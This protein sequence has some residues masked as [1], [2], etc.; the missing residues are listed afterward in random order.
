MISARSRAHDR[1]RRFTRFLAAF[2][3]GW[4]LSPLAPAD[5]KTRYQDIGDLI[6]ASCALNDSLD[7]SNTILNSA[8]L[9]QDTPIEIQGN[10]HGWRRVYRLDNDVRIE[11]E[12][13]GTPN[14]L[15][16]LGIQYDDPNGKPKLFVAL[17]PDCDIRT[18]REIEYDQHGRAI[19]IEH[20]DQQ[21]HATGIS[22]SLNPT[23]PMGDQT[24]GV[25][26]A[27]V[28][29]G[30]NYQLRA[31]GE[32]L[33]RDQNGK[34]IGYDFWDMDPL[35]FDANP[36][37]SP[38][39][40][41]R[42]GT[43]TASLIVREAPQA[44][45]VPY[46]YPR[47]DMTRMRDVIEHAANANVRI[48]A[49]PL[50]SNRPTEWQTFAEAA[51]D[52]PEMLFIVSAGNNNRNIDEFPVYPAAMDLDNLLVVTSADDFAKP[53]KGSNW[54]PLSVDLLIPA[55]RQLVTDFS[56]QQLAASG[57]SYAVSRAA[58]MAARLLT[59]YPEWDAQQLKAEII[60]NAV[61]KNMQQY[62]SIGLLADPLADTA[63]VRRRDQFQ[64]ELN[65]V[66][67]TS[68]VPDLHLRVDI[69]LL[70]QS[71][72]DESS[73]QSMVTETATILA[74]CNIMLNEARV[75]VAEVSP[76]LLDLAM[77]T[78]KTLVDTIALPH[79]T[80]YLVRDTKMEIPFG[81]EAFGRA[82]T[83]TRTWLRDS[84]WLTASISDPGVALAHE[85]FHVI[86]NSGEHVRES[87][88]LMGEQTS[89][90]NTA[91][92]RH[93]C[94]LA[95]QQGLAAGLLTSTGAS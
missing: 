22:D 13:I 94:D 39:F 69:A 5:H 12:R 74:Q 65:P 10:Q 37:N 93:Q 49:L 90:G 83:E 71:G 21:F 50:G 44:V 23:L 16:S 48:F 14:H 6:A 57:S 52:H 47:P 86:A 78:A 56:G 60:K 9:E 46:R 35:P 33:A 11:L 25:R 28:D 59:R 40:P 63:S 26:V 19:K 62:V 88:N 7:V 15:R 82:N 55:E 1:G 80:V 79:P 87:G 66:R 95:R 41:Q 68:T 75:V 77:G 29:S 24:L 91:L 31:I 54:G 61:S 81:G 3:F 17:G 53:A 30:V 2:I 73:I 8:R 45:I 42:H 34:M 67:S 72:W 43:R 4:L 20:L 76:Y 92:F 70:Q 51:R 84:V 18:V 85:L 36:A 32:H 89:P 27:L 38:F 64:L 58:A